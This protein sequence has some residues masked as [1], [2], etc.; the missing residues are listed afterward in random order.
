MNVHAQMKGQM[1][2]GGQMVSGEAD[3]WIE[4]LNP[5]H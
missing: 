5:G 2:I 4:S 1:L 3:K